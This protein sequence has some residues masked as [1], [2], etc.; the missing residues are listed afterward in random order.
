MS[1]DACTRSTI[2]SGI[3]AT[4]APR[5]RELRDGDAGAAL[6]PRAEAERLHARVLAQHLGDAL[7]QRPGAL[8][9]DDAE[10]LEVR[11]DG[12]VEGLEEDVVHLA[13]AHAAQV[14]LARRVHLRHVAEYRHVD[15]GLRGLLRR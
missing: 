15:L 9:V 3:S 1:A 7:A 11:A 8:A 12:R 14:D 13:E 4:A 5:S 2:S 6:V 10:R